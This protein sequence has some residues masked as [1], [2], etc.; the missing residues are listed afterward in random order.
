MK[1]TIGTLALLLTSSAALLLPAAAAAQDRDDYG[2]Y[3]DRDGYT[4]TWREG[5]YR[6]T[7]THRQRDHFDRSDRGNGYHGDR[8]RDRR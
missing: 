4:Q 3:G 2:R 7:E 8:D 6:R 1:K 5:R